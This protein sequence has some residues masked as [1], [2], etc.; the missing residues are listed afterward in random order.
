M[1]DPL[2]VAIAASITLFINLVIWLFCFL[3]L[4]FLLGL[5]SFTFLDKGLATFLFFPGLCQLAYMIPVWAVLAVKRRF[6]LLK[7]SALG[8]ALTALLNGVYWL[9]F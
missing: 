8:A 4:L 9:F 2:I 1:P 6:N 7:G 5:I 3:T